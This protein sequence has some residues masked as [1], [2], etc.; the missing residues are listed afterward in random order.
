[1]RLKLWAGL[2]GLAIAIA[3]RAAAEPVPYAWVQMVQGGAEV[4]AVTPDGHCP[5]LSFD[6]KPAPMTLRAS[7]DDAFPGVCQAAV[8]EAAREAMIDG[9]ALPLPVKREV[10]RIV[11]FGDTGCRIKGPV[12]QACNDPKAWPLAEVA[13]RAAE[14]HPDLI[15]HVGD[16]YYRESPCPVGD[17]RCEGS[18][19]GDR[20]D[21]WR[22]DFFAPSEPL[23]RAAPWVFARG[24]H[25]SCKRGGKGWF[26]LL[27]AAP[28]AKPCP[29]VAEP[30]AVPIGGLNL[31]VLDSADTQDRDAPPERVAAFSHQLDQL[32]GELAKS[33][34]WIVTHRP[35]WA[36]TPVV[37]VGPIGPLNLP[38]NVTEQAAVKG[39]D[40]DAVRMV[41]SGHV[42]D[43][44]SLDFGPTRPPQLVVGTGGDIGE[45]ADSPRIT[46]D[47]ISI[48]GMVARR[49]EFDRFGYL[50][51]D[52]LGEGADDW[53]GVFYDA[54]DRP[55]VRCR[56][57]QR[58]LACEPAK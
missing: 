14:R 12:V 10:R 38:L 29:A 22:A 43:F 8:P 36:L 20:W 23:L 31:Y 54:Q 3:G 41:V 44:S 51:L 13:R 18:P 32:K 24:N 16:Y 45:P 26:R 48:D 11:L 27:D 53:A 6:G 55:V 46:R 40:L 5:S 1:M 9:A 19:S 57:Y 4:R 49:V 2:A 28:E 50:V 39:H 34:G 56:L 33:P 30:F 42:H 47:E 7:A 37:R 25:E 52:R 58:N 21:A 15:I 35:V 17:V